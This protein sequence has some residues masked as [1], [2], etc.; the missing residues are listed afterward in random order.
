MKGY[1][2]TMRLLLTALFAVFVLMPRLASPHTNRLPPTRDSISL[3]VLQAIDYAE[4]IRMV[5]LTVCRRKPELVQRLPACSKVADVPNSVIEKMALP[6]FNRHVSF[7]NAK[8]ALAFWLTPDGVNISAKTRR[9]TPEDNLK[10][11]TEN[12]QRVLGNFN[13]SEAGV[14]LSRLAGDRAVSQAMIRAIGA[15]AL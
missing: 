1:R 9:E 7:N 6:H 2:A 4:H 14:A 8:A 11:L 12:E 5:T 3:N 10:L 15:Y 13:R